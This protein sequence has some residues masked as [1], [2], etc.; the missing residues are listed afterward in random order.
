MS[1]DCI[2][3]RKETEDFS[4][5]SASML[6]TAGVATAFAARDILGN[7]LNGAALYLYTPFSIGDNIKVR[8]IALNVPVD[9]NASKVTPPFLAVRHGQTFFP[10][11]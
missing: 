8:V 7:F 4:F 2:I 10:A 11:L 5:I 9:R 1:L 3:Q 6:P